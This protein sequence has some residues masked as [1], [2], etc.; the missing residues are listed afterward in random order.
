[1]HWIFET[2][3]AFFYRSATA[4]E[5]ME[6]Y[7]MRSY[8]SSRILLVFGLVWSLVLY[9]VLRWI[10]LGI[11]LED[12]YGNAVTLTGFA[13]VLLT[14]A[15]LRSGWMAVT[16]AA[17]VLFLFGIGVA[18]STLAIFGSAAVVCWLRNS[19]SSPGKER[20]ALAAELLSGAST[21]GLAIGIHPKSS[22]V[23]GLCTWLFY[24]VQ[25]TPLAVTGHTELVHGHEAL[26]SKFEAT[27]RKVER[28]LAASL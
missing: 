27:R 6:E 14:A 16:F 11:S 8:P 21:I 9:L 12:A 23:I 13:L 17:L 1:M 4:N 7:K 2:G 26:R 15:R 10:P 20:F 19:R 22:M 18:D 25:I 5:T 24:L 3:S 28:I